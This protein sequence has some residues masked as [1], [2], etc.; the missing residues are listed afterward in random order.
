VSIRKDAI[1]WL[2]K[3]VGVVSERQIFASKLF[4]PG[5]SWT[6]KSAWWIQIPEERITS[7]EFTHLYLLCQTAPASQE[8]SVLRVPVSYFH[9]NLSRF[10][11]IG[12]GRINLFL[13][14]EPDNLFEDERGSGKIIFASFL[15]KLAET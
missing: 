15:V 3:N 6:N 12:K 13:S 9:Q 14:A 11:K 2:K 1:I 10:A 7:K 8:F 4:T 5:E